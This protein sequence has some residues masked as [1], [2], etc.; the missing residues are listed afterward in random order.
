VVPKG[1]GVERIAA[2]LKGRGV[3]DDPRLFPHRGAP[4]GDAGA[5]RAG[6]YAFPAGASANRAME[7]L[8]SG[9]VVQHLL[10][11]PRAGR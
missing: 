1:A 6:E 2:I 8:A 9:Q 4:D 5:L 7:I 10:T 3:I 11:I